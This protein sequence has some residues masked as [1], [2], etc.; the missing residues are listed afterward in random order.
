M[1]S[2]APLY[3]PVAPVRTARPTVLPGRA[4][5]VSQMIGK[6]K[7]HGTPIRNVFVQHPNGSPTRPSKLA[8]FGRAS[9]L[10][11]F[12][13]VHTLA[14]AKD[15]YEVTYPSVAWAR[16]LNLDAGSGVTDEDTATAVRQWSKIT[17][18]LRDL[19][20]VSTTRTGRGVRYTLL[21]ESGNGTAYTR[22]KETADG[23][24]FTLP[25]VYWLEDHYLALSHPAKL[26]LLVALSSKERFALPLERTKEWYGISRST[27]QRGL[28]ELQVQGL[29]TYEQ[30]WRLD[31]ANKRT[32]SEVR[33]YRLLGPYAKNS[34]RESMTNRKFAST[35]PTF[36]DAV[37]EAAATEAATQESDPLDP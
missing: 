33:T 24:W 5:F 11:A 3:E 30:S 10:D 4:E 22:P 23:N 29:L 9:Y 28:R 7:R 16:S 13:W 8:E 15:P 35:K 21:D 27:A 26:M 37:E 18:K 20:L 36:T 32:Y 2:P 19:Q 1:T 17:R 25:D 34:I 31:T 12:L 6:T 14:S